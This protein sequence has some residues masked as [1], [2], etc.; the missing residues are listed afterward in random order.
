MI[1]ALF[2]FVIHITAILANIQLTTR[3]HDLFL[4][5]F[6]GGADRFYEAI[7]QR[8]DWSPLQIFE[9]RDNDRWADDWKRFEAMGPVI[10]CPPNILESF[11]EGDGEKRVCG[12]IKKDDCVVISVG[13]NNEW[14]F[15]LDLIAKYPQC[16]VYTFDCY[17][18][19]AQVPNKIKEQVTFY[20]ICLG[21]KDT[22]IDG[23]EFM[24]WGSVAKKLELKKPPSALKMDIEGFEWTTIPAIIKS[25]LMVPESFSFELHFRTD[26]EKFRNTLLWSTRYRTD[27]EIGLFMELLYSL[28]YVLVDR[29]DNQICGYCTEI[30]ISKLIPSTRFIHH[31][32]MLQSAFSTTSSNNSIVNMKTV[33]DIQPYPTL[34]Y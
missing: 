29:H 18:S 30:V 2:L 14:D 4:A 13:S 33:L 7:R 11:G 34:P 22:I 3:I 17:Y 24:T 10:Q 23:R 9:F 21:V 25:N 1:L 8:A 20:P 26:P 16:K 6:P 5:N 32:Q 28:G 27:P 19:T 12:S 15:E 31:H